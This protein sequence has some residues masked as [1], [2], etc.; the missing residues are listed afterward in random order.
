ML[1]RFARPATLRHKVI[2][3]VESD[4]LGSIRCNVEGGA[5]VLMMRASHLL[6]MCGAASASVALL[7][8]T[9]VNLTP[10]QIAA[11]SKNNV[12]VYVG[13]FKG[14]SVFYSPPGWVVALTPTENAD[15]HGVRVTLMPAGGF[16][17]TL[18][19]LQAL[20]KF[21]GADIEWLSQLS[22]LVAVERTRRT[23]S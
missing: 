10:E 12:D 2:S 11:M 1:V 8:S 22:E 9:L 20:S 13:K 3:D 21:K 7:K 6:A 23:T 19:E 17:N 18:A 4:Y 5:T 16:D 14:C 15:M